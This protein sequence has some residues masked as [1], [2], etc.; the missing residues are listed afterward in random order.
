ME[1]YLTRQMNGLYMLTKY[2]PII[3]EVEGRGYKDA[4]VPCG[5]PIGI[6]NFCDTILK[7]VNLEGHLN[8]LESVQV[9]LTGNIILK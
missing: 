9:F 1:L 3:C 8:R 4:Y 6:R 7:V 5:D 2:K